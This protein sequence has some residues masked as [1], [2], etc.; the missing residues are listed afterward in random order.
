MVLT[1]CSPKQING[2]NLTVRMYCMMVK[3]YVD[4]INSGQIPSISSAWE[5]IEE[6]ECSRGF[7]SSYDSYKKEL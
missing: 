4:A 2:V 5:F 1:K 7:H 3:R 6:Q